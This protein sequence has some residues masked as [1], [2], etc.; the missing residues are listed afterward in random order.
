MF[1]PEGYPE[2]PSLMDFSYLTDPGPNNAKQPYINKTDSNIRLGKIWI[3]NI[4]IYIIIINIGKRLRL[5][6]YTKYTRIKL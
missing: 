1:H 5:N 3:K 2:H 4:Y 6:I